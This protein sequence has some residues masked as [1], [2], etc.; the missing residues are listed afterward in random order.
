MEIKRDRSNKT[1][2]SLHDGK[3]QKIEVKKKSVEFFFES[4]ADYSDI[5][6]E[7]YPGSV[8]FKN[9]DPSNVS[10]YITKNLNLRKGKGKLEIY[11]LDKFAKKYG[12]NKLEIISETYSDYEIIWTGVFH[13]KNWEEFMIKIWTQGDMVYKMN[14]EKEE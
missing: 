8:L 10:V 3:I 11:P 14:T 12:K 13:K 2:I 1:K 5:K 4:M 9:V 6:M 7:Y